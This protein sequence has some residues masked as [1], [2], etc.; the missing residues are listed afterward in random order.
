MTLTICIIAKDG[1][2]FASDSRASSFLTSN[3][4]VKKIFKLDDHNAVGI[5][6]DGPLAMHFFDTISRQLNFRNGISVLA[7]QMRSLGKARFDEF[8]SH[9]APKDRPS[10]SIILAGYMPDG[11]PEI[12]TLNSNDNFVPRKSPIGFE[13]IGIPIIANYLLNR[14]YEPDITTQHAAELATF[15]IKETSSQDNRVGGP[16]QIASFS[17]TK[18]YAE[19]SRDEV[20]KIEQKCDQFRLLQKGNFYPEDSAGGATNP[21][22]ATRS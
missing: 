1:V 17:D 11:K 10:L 21:Q 20:E 19:L 12:Y 14:L 8:F 6:G 18:Q 7:E 5:A 2:L 4:T 22:D 16:T 13:C 9:Q 3:D 15:C